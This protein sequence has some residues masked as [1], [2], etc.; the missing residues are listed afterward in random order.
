SAGLP[1]HAPHPHRSPLSLHDALPIFSVVYYSKLPSVYLGVPLLASLSVTHGFLPPHPAPTAM[2][3]MFGASMATTLIYGL[4]VA[5]PAMIIAGPVFA[6]FFRNS[7]AKLPALF[8][9][10]DIPEDP[11]PGT[12]N[13][14]ATACLPV[15]FLPRGMPVSQPRCT[16][17]R[18]ATALLPVVRIAGSAGRPGLSR[19][20][21][22]LHQLL[23][24]LAVPFVVM[25]VALLGASITLGLGRGMRI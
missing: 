11:L 9:P 21:A 22:T 13:C 1:T 8:V 2:V 19:E 3:P 6:R 14:F 17:S 7:R 20:G 23:L 24:F 12:F 5:V 25:R 4:F 16:F 15:R 10:Q 18:F